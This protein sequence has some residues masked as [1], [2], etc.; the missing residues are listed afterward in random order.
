MPVLTSFSCISKVQRHSPWEACPKILAEFE[1]LVSEFIPHHLVSVGG[2]CLIDFL[3]TLTDFRT[4]ILPSQK[5]VAH[6]A[7]IKD[8]LSAVMSKGLSDAGLIF[9][10]KRP[11]CLRK[12]FKSLVNYTLWPRA[13]WKGVSLIHVLVV[14]ETHTLKAELK[15]ALPIFRGYMSPCKERC[16]QLKVN[17]YSISIQKWAAR[18][19][20]ANLEKK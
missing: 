19:I 11:T 6:D 13:H 10:K 16:F 7:Q 18:G 2:I 8:V 4:M 15:I 14:L 9:L 20:H 5:L 3:T 12:R 17:S 1:V